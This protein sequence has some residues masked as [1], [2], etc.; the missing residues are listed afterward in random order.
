M[1]RKV[2]KGIFLNPDHSTKEIN[3]A[4][5]EID[6]LLKCYKSRGIKLDYMICF[7]FS[8]VVF[9]NDQPQE[10]ITND[11]AMVLTKTNKIIYGP[12]IILDDFLD[13]DNSQF[14]KLLLIAREIPSNIWL[15][16][17]DIQDLKNDKTTPPFILYSLLSTLPPEKERL[18]IWDKVKQ[19]YTD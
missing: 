19:Y 18:I 17:P 2:F 7:G 5:D 4:L 16:E 3:V 9:Y 15:P 14:N 6:P 1:K 12:V 13:L 10:K 11:L 8:C